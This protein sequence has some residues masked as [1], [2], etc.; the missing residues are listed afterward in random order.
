MK[1]T[2]Y[3]KID[4][5]HIE[6][7]DRVAHLKGTTRSAVIREYVLAGIRHESLLQEARE[8][9]VPAEPEIAPTR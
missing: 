4:P 5:E 3:I 9:P 8:L 7:I 2:C 1:E 6:I